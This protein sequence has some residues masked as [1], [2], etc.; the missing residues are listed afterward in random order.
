MSHIDRIEPALR[1][2]LAEQFQHL[3]DSLVPSLPILS[4]VYPGTLRP[5]SFPTVLCSQSTWLVWSRRFS[6][7]SAILWT[8]IARRGRLKPNMTSSAAGS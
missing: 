3:A 5:S 2:A 4:S 7:S 6:T 8:S 1:Q